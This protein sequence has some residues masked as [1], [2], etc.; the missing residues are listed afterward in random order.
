MYVCGNHVNMYY[1][2]SIFNKMNAFCSFHMLNFV[3]DYHVFV[4]H[5]LI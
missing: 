4:Y 2:I 5:D 3:F 1:S